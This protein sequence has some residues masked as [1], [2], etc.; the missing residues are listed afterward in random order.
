MT[1][2]EVIVVAA[3][4]GI[5][6]LLAVL[7]LKPS[8]QLAKAFDSRRKADVKGISVALEDYINDHPC[9]PEAI[10]DGDQCQPS[11]EFQPYMNNIPCDPQTK[12]QYYYFR[13]DD[14][15]Q[16]VIYATLQLE[17]G[18]SYGR[19]NW[20]LSSSNLRVIP[21][22]LVT[23]TEG[24]GPTPTQAPPQPTPT[25][26]PTAGPAKYYGCKSGICV[27]LSGP[28]CS[29]NYDLPNCRNQCGSPENPLNECH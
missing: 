26:T 5:L 22:V 27:E 6:M 10:Y 2:S 28:E 23:P 8:F 12:E 3:I 25:I 13:P 9:Y 16:Y 24:V 14:C 21:T 4:L 29:P 19:G 17:T 15:S 18:I 1:L 11:D 20:A 7:S